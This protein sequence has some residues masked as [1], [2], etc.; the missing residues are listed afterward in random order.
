MQNDLLT[1]PTAHRG[2]GH[3]VPTSQT[4]CVWTWLPE[5]SSREEQDTHWVQFD[6]RIGPPRIGR[7]VC[8]VGAANLKQW[9]KVSPTFQDGSTDG[10]QQTPHT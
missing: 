5:A 4:P 10:P 1:P 9:L 2:S 6:L 7:T 3:P 8:R